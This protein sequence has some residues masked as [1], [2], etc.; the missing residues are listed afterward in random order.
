MSAYTVDQ[1]PYTLPVV[2]VT[3]VAGRQ[4]A[5]AMVLAAEKSMYSC[6]YD[7]IVLSNCLLL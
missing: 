3:D 2:A 7:L 1:Q 5:T 4:R 6:Y